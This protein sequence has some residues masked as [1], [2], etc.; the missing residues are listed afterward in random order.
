M[1]FCQACKLIG[2]NGGQRGLPGDHAHDL[3]RREVADGVDR[4]LGVVGRIR[5]KDG[6]GQREQRVR[7]I[8]VALL[9]RFLFNVV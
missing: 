1:R 5:R 3:V 7:R 6:I 2:V 4:F 9:G 8:L